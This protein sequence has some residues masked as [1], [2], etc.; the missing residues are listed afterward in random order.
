MI[1]VSK[2]RVRRRNKI[3]CEVED[4]ATQRGERIVILGANGS[5]KTT[6]VRV[7]AGFEKGFEGRVEVG[8]PMR[9]RVYVHQSPYLFRGTV[10]ANVGYGLAARG[11]LTKATSA[12][13]QALMDRLG[14]AQLAH[15]RVNGLSGGERRRVALARAFVLRPPLLLLDEPFAELDSEAT[16]RVRAELERCGEETTVIV[17]SPLA[18]DGKWGDRSVELVGA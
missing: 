17:T 7:L 16:E 5:G 11:A 8:V 3:L 14:I 6:F 2:L 15:R 1:T 9:D 12:E 18:L 10:L 4:F 13:A